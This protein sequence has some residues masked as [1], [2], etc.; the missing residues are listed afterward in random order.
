M[1]T[2]DTKVTDWGL[3][4]GYT[5]GQG[6]GQ[7]HKIKSLFWI[8]KSWKSSQPIVIFAHH[9]GASLF[10]DCFWP[11]YDHFK[12]NWMYTDDTNITDWGPGHG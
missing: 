11:L 5:Q 1:Y 9:N 7:G 3:G 12:V 4:R 8:L 6:Q 10:L 2:D